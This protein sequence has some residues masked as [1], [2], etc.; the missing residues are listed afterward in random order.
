MKKTKQAIVQHEKAK[1]VSKLQKGFLLDDRY[2]DLLLRNSFLLLAGFANTYKTTLALMMIVNAVKQS[3]FDPSLKLKK[4]VT[5]VLTD[6]VSDWYIYSKL[7]G[8]IQGKKLPFFAT[9]SNPRHDRR[10]VEN[11]F[12][13]HGFDFCINNVYSFPIKKI[14]DLHKDTDVHHLVIDSISNLPIEIRYDDTS[15]MSHGLNTMRMIENLCKYRKGV[16]VLVAH[17]Q[18]ELIPATEPGGDPTSTPPRVVGFPTKARF[19]S[20]ME[21]H[22]QSHKDG[23]WVTAVR[24]QQGPTLER[25]CMIEA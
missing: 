2:P 25:Y 17:M 9:Q 15:H 18:R 13:Q 1:L 5:L 12:K 6:V 20:D 21:L 10:L 4:V 16:K 19:M 22:A 24:Y 3:V 23:V 14:E 7:S 11:F 8:I